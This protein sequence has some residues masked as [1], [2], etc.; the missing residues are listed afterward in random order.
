MPLSPNLPE[1]FVSKTRQMDSGCI[2]WTGAK[3][4]DGY[5]QFSVNQFPR[6]AHR[7]SYCASYG[8][9]PDGLVVLHK[10]DNPA[11]VNPEHLSIGTVKD[12]V[13]DAKRKGRSAVKNRHGRRKVSEEDIA[14]IRKA[15]AEGARLKDIGSLHGLSESG[16]S[17]IC[18]GI[19]WR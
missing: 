18:R 16:V 4:W 13:F 15:R 12:N 2:E 1:R 19:I 3:F 8:E 7:I 10:C 17:K 14:G 11:C 9:I 6:R 5:G